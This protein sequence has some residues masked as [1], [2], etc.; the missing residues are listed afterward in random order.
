MLAFAFAVIEGKVEA[1]VQTMI[2]TMANTG[3]DLKEYL[4]WLGSAIQAYHSI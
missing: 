3:S 1:A 4:V 2:I